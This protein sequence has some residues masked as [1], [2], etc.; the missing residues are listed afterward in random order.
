[1]S[2]QT[3]PRVFGWQSARMILA[4]LAVMMFAGRGSGPSVE[5]QSN[6]I[7][8]ENNQGGSPSSEW[9]VTGAGD[10]SIQGFATDISVNTGD[11]VSFKVKTDSTNY[12]IDIYRLGYY[13]GA[14]ARL[15]AANLVPVPRTQPA[16]LVDSVTGLAD[17]GN[18][19][20]SASWSTAGA[21][22]GI[23][24]AKLR[25]VDTGGASHIV[26]IV[27]NDARQADVVMQTS[28]TTWQAYNRYGG[29]SL[30]CG[31]PQSNIGTVYGNACSGRATKVSY[32]RPFDT[33]GHDATSFLFN[34]EYPMVRW[35]EANGYD[36]KYI[37]GVDTE[38][39][40]GDL[41]GASTK[42]KAFLS[43][44]H[45]EYWSA[46]Q[47]ASVE[48]ARNA[49]VNLAFFSGN[50][51]YWKTRFEPSADGTNTPYRTLVGYKD[52]L[53]GVKL[54]PTPGVTTGTWR[55][56]RFG[57][58][59]ADGGRPE[60]G[61]IGQIWTVNQGT[62]AITVPASMASL[63]FW[64]NTTVAALT[65]GSATLGT[66]TLG[67]EWGEDLDN[68]AR[69]A[70]V[71]HL[72]STTVP[73][74]EKILDFGETV[75]IG[76]ATHTLTL[77]K[78]ASGALVFGA[79]TVQWAWGLDGNH[80]RGS[81]PPSP[82]MQQATMNLLADMGAQPGTVQSGLIASSASADV[83]AP[84][85]VVTVAPRR[86]DG[87]E[88]RSCHDHRHGVRQRRRRRSRRSFRRRR[89]D[90]ACRAGCGGLEL[91]V[92]SGRA[93][94]CHTPQPRRRRQR[95]PGSAR[96]RHDRVGRPE[97]LPVPEPL[98]RVDGAGDRRCGR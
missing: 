68:G 62:S 17:C 82:A 55:D 32:N 16:C 29:G 38:R 54:D 59:V 36:V 95:Q 93:R 6:P 81:A 34:A 10:P 64:R 72:S 96:R 53:G 45:D 41:I 94:S 33:R 20:V 8:L 18:W 89:H 80:D 13:G 21:V 50:E 3:L 56:T 74:V 46:G 73:G 61:L 24:L 83:A 39:R 40:A 44:G 22:S 23:Y 15:V 90:V 11:L 26:F 60:N 19:D 31:G 71:I 65:T 5:A 49:G 98:E 57:P 14:G 27:R 35:L 70:G 79:G 25:R 48:A 85:S 2:L 7:V 69:P 58:P 9:D 47:R 51:I 63:R 1:M 4:A 88:R 86:R 75:G 97:Q 84:T 78:H 91:R 87:R 30:Y 67:Y 77:Y 28:D 37:T 42:P 66:D 76:T 12:R 92:V 52:T 43:V